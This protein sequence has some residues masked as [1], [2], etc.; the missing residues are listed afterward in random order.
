MHNPLDDTAPKPGSSGLRLIRAAL[1]F[2]VWLIG[3]ALCRGLRNF[4]T[5]WS[6]ALWG[7]LLLASFVSWGMCVTRGLGDDRPHGWG[8][9]AC[10][11][12]AATLWVFGALACV[13][14]AAGPEIIF[15]SGAGPLLLA[16]DGYRRGT[17]PRWPSPAGAVRAARRGG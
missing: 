2:L 16:V 14:L 17:L 11:G 4:S 5:C 8:L 6:A 9:W 3:L 1:P 10:L 12:M 13:R 7:F 15:W